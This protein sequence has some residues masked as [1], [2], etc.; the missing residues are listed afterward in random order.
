MIERDHNGCNCVGSPVWRVCR[1]LLLIGYTGVMLGLRRFP[2][3]AWSGKA[4]DGMIGFS[5]GA[6]GGLAGLSGPLPTIWCGIQSHLTAA[7]GSENF[8]ALIFSPLPGRI[9][10]VDVPWATRSRFA[11]HTSDSA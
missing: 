4:A 3:I 10:N 9:I 2:S 6:L 1:G 7:L 5:G 11:F 8:G